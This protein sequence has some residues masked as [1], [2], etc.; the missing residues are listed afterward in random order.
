MIRKL[1]I[2]IAWFNLSLIGHI[3]AFEW[4]CR[5]IFDLYFDVYAGYRTDEISTLIRSSDPP[6]TPIRRNRLRAKHIRV[7][8]LG[9]EG[10]LSIYRSGFGRV[11]YNTGVVNSGRYKDKTRTLATGV[12]TTVEADIHK[13]NMKDCSVGIGYMF[14]VFSCFGISNK[15]GVAPLIGWSRNHQKIKMRN[16]TTITKSP[17]VKPVPPP[18]PSPAPTFDGL[19]YSTVWNGP[20][21]G[22]EAFFPIYCLDVNLAYELHF[23]KWHATWKLKGRDVLGG[24]F[25]DVRH[26]HSSYGSKTSA[27]LIYSLY[28]CFYV[29][30]ELIFRY[31]K[32]KK[33][34]EK[35][36]AG[37]FSAVGLKDSQVDRVKET[38]WKSFEVQ[39]A[40]GIQY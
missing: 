33:G 2:L 37:T 20:W 1:A 11:Y 15:Y 23:P 38:L 4:N 29:K 24:P 17:F 36:I 34:R 16:A 32:A 9:V 35:P 21:I 18:V 8:D 10:R 30:T 40:L 28:E 25:S 6:Q 14:P 3:G 12:E 26:A 27:N 19:V 7:R 13:G 22:V 31:W 5:N 39:I